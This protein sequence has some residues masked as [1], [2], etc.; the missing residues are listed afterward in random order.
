M[1]ERDDQ[2]ALRRYAKK[3]TIWQD[4]LTTT[5]SAEAKRLREGIW[6]GIPNIEAKK[7]D[8]GSLFGEIL[9]FMLAP[10][11]LLWPLSIALTFLVARS[12]ADTPFDQSLEDRV[13]AVAQQIN[14]SKGAM[15]INLPQPAREI[16]KTDQEDEIYFQVIDPSGSLVAGDP[17]VPGPSLYDFP[18]ADLIKFRNE[19]VR[20][21]ELRIAYLR[22]DFGDSFDGSFLVQVAE[23]MN[24]RAAL[25]NEIIRGVILPQFIILPLSVFLV[26]FGLKRGLMPVTR[27]R[28]QI[29]TR[30]QN[31]LSPLNNRSMPEE[32]APVVDSFNELLERLHH[33][34]RTQQRFIA[35]AAHQ[36]KTP[37]AGLQTQAELAMRQQNPDEQRATLKQLSRSA[38][39]T[40]RLVT[41]L[42][43]MARA[44]H[45]RATL[46][47]APFNLTE[48]GRQATE[49]WA[50]A[51]LAKNIDIGFESNSTPSFVTGQ[52]VVLRE[53]MNNL[54][55]N[56]IRYTPRDGTITV[57][58]YGPN[59]GGVRFEVE[60]NGPGIAPHEHEKVFDRFYRVLGNDSDGS[61]LGLAIVRE[62]AEQ[63]G[64]QV[65]LN[66]YT[67]NNPDRMPQG[68][69][70]AFI[71]PQQ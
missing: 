12:L 65:K 18:Q 8:R 14:P 69:R 48:L 34:M 25:A 29:D 32:I 4:L 46:P 40:A 1:N 28:N 24:K 15:V 42:L 9:D 27:L 33:T 20:G 37:L 36:M 63:H 43:A 61:G 56:A 23:T 39:R 58:V 11:L 53:M 7:N 67:A 54:I 17:I 52:P 57:R 35:D 26:W 70:I 19:V 71:F 47:M 44:E 68:T 21:S 41:Q 31:D 6:S 55:D 16:L 66:S 64:A 62:I 60:D 2:R 30:Q 13:N 10:L 5:E 38:N 45:H 49:E 3:T 59:F 22:I 51:A 50:N